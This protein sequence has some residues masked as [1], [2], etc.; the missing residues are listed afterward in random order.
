MKVFFQCGTGHCLAAPPS[1]RVLIFQGCALLFGSLFTIYLDI[2][3]V[4][5]A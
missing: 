2:L 1:P 4:S 3:L 5:T